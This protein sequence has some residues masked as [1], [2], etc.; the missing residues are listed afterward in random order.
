MVDRFL[1]IFA[2]LPHYIVDAIVALSYLW[3][4]PPLELLAAPPASERA[5][6]YSFLLSYE[7]AREHS[8]AGLLVIGNSGRL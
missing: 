7:L 3:Y 6:I 8:C 4:S 1:A 5:D 2:P